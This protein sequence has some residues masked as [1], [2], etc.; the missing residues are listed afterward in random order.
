MDVYGTRIRRQC[1][2]RFTHALWEHL[3]S[4]AAYTLSNGQYI[5]WMYTAAYGSDLGYPRIVPEGWG[6]SQ[7]ENS[8]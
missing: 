3:L 2:Y 5:D 8:I 1:N 7:Y 6:A 4:P